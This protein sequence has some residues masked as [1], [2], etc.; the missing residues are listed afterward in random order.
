MI[1]SQYI[2]DLLAQTQNE[3]ANLNSLLNKGTDKA[4]NKEYMKHIQALNK[5]TLALQ[6]YKNLDP[7]EEAAKKKW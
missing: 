1:A 5:I 3:L 6:Q 4:L 7:P 2:N